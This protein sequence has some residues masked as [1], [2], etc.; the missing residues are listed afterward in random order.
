M[1]YSIKGWD[2]D[3]TGLITYNDPNL[4]IEKFSR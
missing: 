4:S 3:F 1:I 2:V